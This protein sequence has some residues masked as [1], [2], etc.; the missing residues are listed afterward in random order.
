MAR[1]VKADIAVLLEIDDTVWSD[2]F[3]TMASL[4]VDEELD[5]SGLSEARLLEIERNLAAH[6]YCMK[7]V[8]ASSEGAGGVSV[9]YAMSVGKGLDATLYGQQAMM[10]DTSGTLTA[11]NNKKGRN[12]VLVESINGYD[13]RAL[14]DGKSA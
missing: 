5:E 8:R 10:F 3:I 11:I 12:R 7:D 9:S 1:V 2:A 14:I 6:F 4:L 13:E